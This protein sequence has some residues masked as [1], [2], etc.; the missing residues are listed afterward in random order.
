MSTVGAVGYGAGGA[1]QLGNGSTESSV[2]PA[3]GGLA[4]R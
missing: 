1:G 4:A 2:K 3:S